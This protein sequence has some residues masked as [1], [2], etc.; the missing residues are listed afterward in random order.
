MKQ[1]TMTVKYFAILREQTGL[2]SEQITGTWQTLGEVY[3]ELRKR[4]G[5]MLDTSIVR[6]ALGTAYVGW[7]A[8]PEEG[9]TLALIPPVSGG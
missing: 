5:F 7:D 1:I 9:G 4:H 2:Q 6:A 3:D 8:A